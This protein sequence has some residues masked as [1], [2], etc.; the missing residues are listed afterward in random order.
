MSYSLWGHKESD[1]TEQLTL[2]GTKIPQAKPHNVAKKKER[3]KGFLIYFLV[4]VLDFF[5]F[6]YNPVEM[7]FITTLRHLFMSMICTES[8]P[9]LRKAEMLRGW[10]PQF[11]H[12][13]KLHPQC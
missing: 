10:S 11:D 4:F 3:K 1:T 9:L 12:L 7:L 2:W 8:H 6:R 13:E 5:M